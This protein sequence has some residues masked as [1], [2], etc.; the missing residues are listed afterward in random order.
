MLDANGWTPT[1]PSAGVAYTISG[2]Q[3]DVGTV[4][5]GDAL[6]AD[7][8]IHAANGVNATAQVT[9]SYDAALTLVLDLQ[10]PTLHDP[11]MEI[12]NP[13]GSTYLAS[14]TPIGADRVLLRTG[15]KP[16]FTADFP[17]DAN[18]DIFANAGFLQV[19]LQG[20]VH[21]CAI[22]AGAD[23]TDPPDPA[24][25]MLQVDLKDNGDLTFGDVVTLLLN[26]PGSLLS[27]DTNIRAT[28]GVD[29]SVPGAPD[30]LGSQTA[31]ADFHWNDLKQTSGAAGPTFEA[32]DLSELLAFD[33]DPSNPRAL[34]SIILKT[35]QTLDAALGNADPTDPAAAVFSEKIPVVGRSLRDLLRTDE[36]GGGPTVSYSDNSLT[37]TS[38]SSDDGNAFTQDLVNRTV[39]V[40]TQVGVVH[41]VTD[42]TLTMAQNWTTKPAD[43]TSYVLRSELDDAISWLEAAP[44]DNLQELVRQLD[45]RLSGTPLAFEY[46]DTVGQRLV[47]LHL[48]WTRSYHTSAPVQFD[49]NIPAG[50][51]EVAGVKGSG[52]VALDA[53]GHIQMG[54]VIPLA[55]GD[56]PGGPG[57]L[58]ILDDS[59]IG[60]N[61]DA[62]VQRRRAHVHPG[63]AQALARRP[64]RRW[65]EGHGP[66]Q[67]L[68]RPRR[69]LV[70]RYPGLVQHLHGRRR[71]RAERQQRSRPLR[72]RWRGRSAGAVRQLPALHQHGWGSTY[73]KVVTDPRSS[74][75]FAIRLPK[76]TTPTSDYFD[77]AGAQIDG[78][79]RL[80][81]PDPADLADAILANI[82]DF[83]QM[84]GLDDYLRLI[85]TALNE[86]SFGGKIPLIGDDLQQGADFVGNL[87]TAINDALGRPARRRQP[88]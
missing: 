21:V 29:A 71:G 39:V 56:G 49:F 81:T 83:G 69:Q 9:P 77:L 19:E 75:A 42:N 23:C 40:G 48:D 47:I 14:A 43:G 35:L 70:D 62:D 45:E 88:R 1:T 64:L 38:R 52:S 63:T 73:D 66:G 12:S 53:G 50:D 30:F 37:D 4:Q 13:D 44:S 57:D 51:F 3:G 87:R 60:V 8:G 86:A 26:D 2:M 7:G 24:A 28:G 33:F 85:E 55:P 46:Y 22:S 79:D 15:D 16:L 17:I 25:P 74:N 41:A 80:E 54:I 65:R 11:P 58:Q 20:G 32:S 82:I 84:N 31:H 59:S 34:F 68:D 27:F 61:L 67:V 72:P 36:S 76:D 6:A 5:L 78:H 18:A 10:P